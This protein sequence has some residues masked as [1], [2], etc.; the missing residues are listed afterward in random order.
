MPRHAPRATALLFSSA[1]PDLLCRRAGP[2]SSALPDGDMFRRSAASAPQDW[3]TQL[4]NLSPPGQVSTVQFRVRTA[5]RWAAC[6]S[7]TLK[8]KP[9]SLR[10]GWQPC[11]FKASLAR[12]MQPLGERPYRGMGER[13]AGTAHMGLPR[14]AGS[15][16][17][18]EEQPLVYWGF[19]RMGT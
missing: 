15:P 1:A 6:S 11:P 19:H 13:L 3:S 4:Q 9:P 5:R 17:G 12:R 7:S 14:G 10:Q 18:G 2:G 8:P 16:A